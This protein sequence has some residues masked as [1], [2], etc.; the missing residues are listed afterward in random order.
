MES[1]NFSRLLANY[2]YKKKLREKLYANIQIEKS[3][4][5]CPICSIQTEVISEILKRMNISDASI[6]VL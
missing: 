6:I 5:K 4:L 3:I 1:L 2:S